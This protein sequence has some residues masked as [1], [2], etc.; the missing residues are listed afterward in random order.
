MPTLIGIK[1]TFAYLCVYM[2]V[3]VLQGDQEKHFLR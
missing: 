2:L 3:R 1:S